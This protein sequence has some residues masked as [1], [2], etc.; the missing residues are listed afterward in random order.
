MTVHL[1]TPLLVVLETEDWEVADENA[2]QEAL[3]AALAEKG[4]ERW[5]SVEIETFTYRGRRL[6]LAKPVRVLVPDF[7]V[8]LL[9]K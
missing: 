4:L 8:R 2:V 1:T 5:G 7:L 6:L 9:E 3:Q